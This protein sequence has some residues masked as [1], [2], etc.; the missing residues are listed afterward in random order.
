MRG[1][2]PTLS[3]THLVNLLFSRLQVMMSEE[4]IEESEQARKR[5]EK[6]CYSLQKVSIF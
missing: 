5:Q 4:A 3:F 6:R 1:S 2:P